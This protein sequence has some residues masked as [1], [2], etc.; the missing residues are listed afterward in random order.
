MELA[1]CLVQVLTT[2]EYSNGA[3]PALALNCTM[4]KVLGHLVTK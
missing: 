4:T 2:V 3:Y 1:R